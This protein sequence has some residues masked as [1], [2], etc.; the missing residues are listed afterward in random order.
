M[1]QH[2]AAL[3]VSQ[4]ARAEA[5]AL[6]RALDQARNV[7]Q[8][9]VEAGRAHDAQVGMQRR[10]RIVGDLRLGGADGGQE[11]RLA[12]V[13]QSDDAGIGDQLEPQPDGQLL[14]RLAGIGMARRLVGRR[15]EVGVAEPAIAALGQ[16]AHGRRA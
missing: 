16:R 11:R 8:H 1:Q 6:V 10:E 2:A 3:D 15:L 14:A 7:G 5:G 13:G 4:E 12:G 9:E